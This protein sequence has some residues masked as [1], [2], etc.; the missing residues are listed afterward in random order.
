ML[1]YMNDKASPLNAYP[2]FWAPFSIAG[3]GA[4]RRSRADTLRANAG[5]ACFSAFAGLMVSR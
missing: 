1:A 3:E 4:A 5:S 2:A